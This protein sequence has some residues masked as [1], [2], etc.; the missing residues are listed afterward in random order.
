MLEGSTAK[1]RPARS[2]RVR[3]L[4]RGI[5]RARA[6]RSARLSNL[7]LQSQLEGTPM[8]QGAQK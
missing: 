2:S 3:S 4:P 7:G 5:L 6:A 8:R 1:W